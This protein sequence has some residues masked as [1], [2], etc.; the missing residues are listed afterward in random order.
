MWCESGEDKGK[1]KVIIVDFD[2]ISIE[3]DKIQKVI[4]KN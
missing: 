2:Y 1:E 3:S 4:P